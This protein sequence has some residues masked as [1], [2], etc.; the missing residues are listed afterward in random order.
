MIYRTIFVFL[1]AQA[2]ACV[3]TAHNVSA[4]DERQPSMFKVGDEWLALPEV[5]SVLDFNAD[6]TPANEDDLEGQLRLRSTRFWGRLYFDGWPQTIQY[7]RAHF[8]IEPPI[9]RKRFVFAEPRDACTDLTNA[10]LL[11]KDHVLLVH[12][13]TC[14]FGTKA[15]NAEKTAASAIIII[16]NEPGIDHLPGPDAHDIQYS[17]SS[18]AQQEGQLLE[19]FLDDGP[20]DDALGRKLEGY[21]VPINCENSG[22]RCQPATYEERRAVNNLI[23]GGMIA[24][25]RNND[26]TSQLVSSE[27]GKDFPIEYLLAHFGTKVIH[28]NVTMTMVVAKPAD[29]CTPLENDVRGKAVLVRR[30]A[31]PFVKK[32]EEVQAAGGKVMIIG[33]TFPYIVRVGVE[34]RWKGLNTVIPVITVSKRAYR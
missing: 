34:P 17:I 29:A 1:L 3:F 31:C 9:G 2:I 11:T 28:E 18:I 5:F 33:N 7:F 8:G 23:E 32:A 14:T 16:N 30:G 19:A 13:G 12:R 25:H 10:H 21:M 26:K 4:N 27:H 15:K 20:S 22:A 6:S 24:I